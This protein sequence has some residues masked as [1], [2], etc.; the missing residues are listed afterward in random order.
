M[1]IKT[2]ILLSLSDSL[3]GFLDVILSWEREWKREISICWANVTHFK[4][5][6]LPAFSL[7]ALWFFYSPF[8]EGEW[9]SVRFNNFLQLLV[10]D[11][12]SEDINSTSKQIY[13]VYEISE[14]YVLS[15]ILS[16]KYIFF[17]GVR[18]ITPHSMVKIVSF[19]CC[20]W[21]K[22]IP[23]VSV[24]PAKKLSSNKEVF[25]PF[26]FIEKNSINLNHD[27][28]SKNSKCQMFTY[29]SVCFISQRFKTKNVKRSLRKER[30]TLKRS[31]YD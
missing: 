15:Q 31:L 26:L 20:P 14:Y 9:I 5:V 12:E 6:Y 3:S 10:T 28:L 21:S 2:H 27:K 29:S 17:N 23:D 11:I 25:K 18:Q 16:L 19:R 13:F 8:I 24:V 30:D 1:I 7:T 22:D 4:S